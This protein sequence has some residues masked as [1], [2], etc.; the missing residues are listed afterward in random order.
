MTQA[1]LLAE[2]DREAARLPMPL[3]AQALGYIQGLSV[4]ASVTAMPVA[5]L[6]VRMMPHGGTINEDDGRLMMEAIEDAFEQ[7]EEDD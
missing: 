2:I 4:A 1:D 7:V 6:G 5:T 3:M